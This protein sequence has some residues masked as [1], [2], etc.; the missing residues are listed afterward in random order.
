LGV[1]KSRRK[2]Y[3]VGETSATMI[4][5][6]WPGSLQS[7]RRLLDGFAVQVATFANAHAKF[8]AQ[9]LNEPQM[10]E[11]LLKPYCKSILK[12]SVPVVVTLARK[13]VS[14]DQMLQLVPGMMI[15]FDKH[16]DTP[17]TVE[18]AEQPI[19]TGEIVKTGDMFGVRIGEI[20]L[21]A[22]RFI[23]VQAGQSAR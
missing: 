14:I 21:P 2:V 18:I 12:V 1:G 5:A 23:P 19:A 9:P 7:D 3:Q 13:K 16:C 20:V 6:I 15:Q 22:E 8:A 4:T 11:P 10:P 17:M